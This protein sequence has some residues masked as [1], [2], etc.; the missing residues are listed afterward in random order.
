MK[1]LFFFCFIVFLAFSCKPKAADEQPSESA[2]QSAEPNLTAD[3]QNYENEVMKVHDEVMPKMSDIQRLS[4][5]LRGIK[6]TAGNTPEETPVKIEGLDDALTSL[7]EAEQGMMDWMK[8]YTDTKSKVTPDLLPTF[9][10]RELEKIT[11]VKNN[12]L[13]SIEKANTWLAQY[14]GPK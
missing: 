13:N 10:E 14:S 9:Y 4:T 2:E 5:Q 7:R 11:Q 6:A 12:M 3:M 8:Y 1:P